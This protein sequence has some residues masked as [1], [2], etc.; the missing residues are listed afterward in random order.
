MEAAE[1]ALALLARQAQI[2]QERLEEIL[3]SKVQLL[4]IG[5]VAAVPLVAIQVWQDFLLSMAGAVAEE[6]LLL[7]VPQ[8]AMLVAHR[9][10]AAA[11]VLE[12]AVRDGQVLV[13]LA[14]EAH[15]VAIPQEAA[16]LVATTVAQVRQGQTE[17]LVSL[18]LEMVAGL[19]GQEQ[20]AKAE[21]QA[22]TEVRHQAEAE[23]GVLVQVPVRMA[24]MEMAREEKC[25][26]GPGRCKRSRNVWAGCR[27]CYCP[28]GHD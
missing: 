5:L 9:Y 17:H 3:P 27:A 1:A 7:V 14:L 23:Q 16:A 11:E 12:Q 10:M 8:R 6:G 25:V 2:P 21:A 20:A 15:G 24:H 4:E 22:V 13:L 19:A 28:H 26:Y 18:V